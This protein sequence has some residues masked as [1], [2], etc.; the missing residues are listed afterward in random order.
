MLNLL[1]DVPVRIL[2]SRGH[3]TQLARAAVL[4][5]HVGDDGTSGTGHVADPWL[6]LV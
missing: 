1:T 6:S 4:V 2:R 5:L 3:V